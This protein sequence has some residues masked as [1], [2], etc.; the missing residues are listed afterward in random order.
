MPNDSTLRPA[1]R[2]VPSDFSSAPAGPAAPSLSTNKRDELTLLIDS[3]TPIITVETSEEE[4]LESLLVAIAVRLHVRLYS[5]TVTSG[6]QKKTGDLIYGTE[7]PE[8]ALANIGLIEGDA[9]FLLKDFARYCES[10]R[11][12]RRLRDLADKFRTGRRAIVLAA[13][14]IKLPAEI[15]C[16]SSPFDLGLPTAGELEPGVICVLKESPQGLSALESLSQPSIDQLSRNLVGLP[17]DEALRLLRRCILTQGAS[18]SNLLD[19]VLKAKYEA[20]RSEG[21]L[22]SVSRD[23]SFADIVGLKR[24]RQ[25]FETR[26]N[27]FTPEGRRFGLVPPKGV[28]ITGVQGCG[29]SLISRAIAVE[30]GIEVARFDPGALYDKYI[31]ESEKH[32]RKALDLAQRLA[33]MVL[34]VDEI[35]KEFG[36][37][38]PNS[39]ADG[40]LSQRIMATFLTWLQER[41]LGVF[42]VATS[43]SVT[44]LPPELIR[45]GRFDEIFFVDL[46][47]PEER[48][49]LFALHLKKHGRD[50]GVFD[51]QTLASASDGF[52]GAEIE[53]AILA[54]LYTAFGKKQQL[55]TQI[56]LAEIQ[57]TA[58][59]SVTRAAEVNAIREW[60][61]T[62][63][64]PAD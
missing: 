43:N 56:L 55:T 60:A 62:R 2:A 16:E 45:K 58:P 47:G 23:V 48:T 31:G 25:W 50:P 6:L 1:R 29:K 63:A 38:G 12:S 10:D 30:W 26:R 24:L 14:S 9:I 39:D 61:R 40:G 17:E 35:E 57:N 37:F 21:L 27:A 36:S 22:D 19:I 44:S 3:R 13:P 15:E 34:W 33:P 28:L 8:Q 42:L 41:D 59:L 32:L 4:R 20:L 7:Q 51:L 46:P 54:G 11:I 49:G 18:G 64:V 5:W 53:Q 52:S